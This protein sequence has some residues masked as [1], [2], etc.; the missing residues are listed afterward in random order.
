MKV[1]Y[2][3]CSNTL[4]YELIERLTNGMSHFFMTKKSVRLL[5]RPAGFSLAGSTSGYSSLAPGSSGTSAVKARCTLITLGCADNLLGR[6][7]KYLHV[8]RSQSRL[9]NCRTSDEV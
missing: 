5:P 7:P 2:I 9:V 6:T 4:M 1:C 8:H 3:Q